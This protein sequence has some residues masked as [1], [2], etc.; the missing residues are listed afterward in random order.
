MCFGQNG[1]TIIA[2]MKAVA[3]IDMTII[4]LDIEDVDD[5]AFQDRGPV[6]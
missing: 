3:I 4:E 2:W 1:M 5:L 6:S